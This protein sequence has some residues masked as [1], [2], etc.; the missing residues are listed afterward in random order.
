MDLVKSL[1]VN[2]EQKVRDNENTNL[3]D[4]YF[5]FDDET[6]KRIA[7]ELFKHVFENVLNWTPE[8]VRNNL[9]YEMIQKM[10]LTKPYRCIAKSFPKGI[11]ARSGTWYLAK[12]CYPDQIKDCEL[13]DIWK[14]Q[15][16]RVRNAKKGRYLTD[17]FTDA[18]GR[19]KARICMQYELVNNVRFKD[20][21]EMYDYFADTEK[22]MELI[23]AAKLKTPMNIHYENPLEYMHDSLAPDQRSEF[24]LMFKRFEQLDK[25][26]HQ[27]HDQT[28]KR[29]Y[30]RKKAESNGK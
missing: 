22:S 7:V 12:A 20:Q 21:E 19:L 16:M 2:W 25:E 1:I 26:Y 14:M 6:N 5:S 11:E 29:K 8:D 17:F 3:A 9:V 28:K 4:A 23:E 10:K 18:D 24:L 27:A 15:Y 30:T 13:E